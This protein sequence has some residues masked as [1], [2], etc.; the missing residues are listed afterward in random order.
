[1]LHVT[2]KAPGVPNHLFFF[3]GGEL[4]YKYN[5]YTIILYYIVGW[6]HI[7]SYLVDLVS[8]RWRSVGLKENEDSVKGGSQMA[9]YLHECMYLSKITDSYN[10]DYKMQINLILEWVISLWHHQ[11]FQGSFYSSFNIMRVKAALWFFRVCFV[12]F[13]YSYNAHNSSTTWVSVHFPNSGIN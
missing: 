10:K 8:Y 4:I 3:F 2:V 6:Y 7:I 12:L 11:T 1:M 5:N 13:S 9:I